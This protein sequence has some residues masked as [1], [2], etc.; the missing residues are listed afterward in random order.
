MSWHYSQALVE[1]Y[2]E[3]CSVDGERFAL[4]RSSDMPAT[5]CWHDKTTESLTL[6]QYGTTCEPSMGDPGEDLL[7]WY[8]VDFLV[9]TS[10]PPAKVLA[11]EEDTADYGKR[12]RGSLEKLNQ[13][14]SLQ[15]IA[16]CCASED[17][18]S[19]SMTLP[20]WGMML[21]GELWELT[22][23][24]PRTD[25]VAV[26]SSRQL[27]QKRRQSEQQ[28]DGTAS[29]AASESLK[30][31]A[32][33]IKNGSAATAANGLIL[34]I[35]SGATVANGADQSTLPTPSGTSNHGSNNSVARLDEW[36]GSSN[37]WRGTADGKRHL[38]SFEEWML[39]WPQ[40]WSALTPLE[41]VKFQQWQLWH[42]LYL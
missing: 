42:G 26:G 25:A 29:D 2:S 1:E 18:T 39:G 10:A 15:R 20:A 31:A 17:S 32:A 19:S 40:G 23:S 21:D 27:N 30:V 28:M 37:P 41:T 4:L 38:P 9:R 24:A 8:R 35:M 14:L 16:P 34:S 33:T 36:G 6:F 13:D 3:V 12:W 7:T 11:L 22:I 5:Y